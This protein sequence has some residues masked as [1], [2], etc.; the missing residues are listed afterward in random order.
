MTRASESI[1][2]GLQFVFTEFIIPIRLDLAAWASSKSGQAPTRRDRYHA[3]RSNAQGGRRA[4]AKRCADPR[5]YDALA[6]GAGPIP[7]LWLPVLRQPM[8]LRA[9]RA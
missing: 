4:S 7:R 1:R 2:L 3:P 5:R 6:A 8:V 9:T